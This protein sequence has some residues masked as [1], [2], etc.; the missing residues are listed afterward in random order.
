MVGNKK[1]QNRKKAKKG[2]KHYW[3]GHKLS[4]R[5]TNFRLWLEKTQHCT[6]TWYKTLPPKK[7]SEFKQLWY[8]ELA[9]TGKSPLAKLPKQ[10]RQ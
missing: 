4:R 10:H 9:E 7:R 5:E 2:N 8:A 6:Y 1:T 3:G